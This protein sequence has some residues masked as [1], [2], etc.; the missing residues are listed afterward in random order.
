MPVDPIHVIAASV[1][2]ASMALLW[3][4]LLAGLTL[5]R[6]WTM[7]RMKHSALLAVHGALAVMGLTLGVV[8]GLAQIAPADTPVRLI[9]TYVP[10]VNPVDP[11]G[12]GAGVVAIEVMISLVVSVALQRWMGFHRWRALHALA[13]AAYT[14]MTIHILVS[15]SE[16]GGLIVGGIVVVP[17]LLIIVLWLI[18]AGGGNSG[19]APLAERL[20][21][22]FRGGGV[23]TVEVN[24][25]KCAR[26]AFCEQEAP[27]VFTLRGDGQLAYRSVVAEENIDATLRA[28]R[29]CPARAIKLHHGSATARLVGPAD[30][31]T[32]GS[33]PVIPPQPGPPVQQPVPARAATN[34]SMPRQPSTNGYYERGRGAA[35]DDAFAPENLFPPADRRRNGRR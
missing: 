11:I 28:A 26:F 35:P 4:A 10:F 33:I 18:P 34:G 25:V 9:D 7:T 31:S 2:F 6:G 1:G 32:T 22:K 13:Y 14:L 21:T 17:W 3:L 30:T 5:A 19:G 8:H 12:I 27:E 29:V 16:T 15:G 24:P 23:T 20:T